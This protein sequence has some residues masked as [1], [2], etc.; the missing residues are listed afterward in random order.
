[1]DP[2]DLLGHLEDQKHSK[3]IFKKKK[4]PFYIMDVFMFFN[5]IIAF[6]SISIAKTEI[7]PMAA[8]APKFCRGAIPP[9]GHF[10]ATKSSASCGVGA[11]GFWALEALSSEMVVVVVVVDDV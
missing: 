6:W 9:A 8:A 5:G 1:M 7:S 10:R 11:S 4:L 2:N 3:P